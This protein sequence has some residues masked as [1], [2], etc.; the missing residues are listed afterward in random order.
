MKS[1]TD[2]PAATVDN[3]NFESRPFPSPLGKGM[4]IFLT[5]QAA[6]RAPLAQRVQ[7]SSG[8]E[9]IAADCS[10]DRRY[11]NGIFIPTGHWR[12]AE[13]G[14]LDTFLNE[15]NG[16]A[17]RITVFAAPSHL[18]RLCWDAGVADLFKSGASASP[19]ADLLIDEFQREA[20]RILK[21]IYPQTT[22]CTLQLYNPNLHSTTYDPEGKTFI[23]LHVDNFEKQPID[24]RRSARSRVV[25]NL[26]V[27]TRSFIFINLDM[28]EVL[29]ACRLPRTPEI[30]QKYAWAYPLAHLFMSTYPNFP[31]TRILL[32]PGEGYIAPTQNLIHD[33]YTVGTTSPDLVLHA[34][35]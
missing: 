25:V 20:T 26:G 18:Y 32:H 34:T 10:D 15:P 8:V 13:Q 3:E 4:R 5:P 12:F 2:I 27:E 11:R 1:H 17:S 29:D 22:H 16:S 23:G 9:R 30:F 35:P 21:A 28:M 7:F 33:G 6:Q 24:Q 14:E 31:V 19:D